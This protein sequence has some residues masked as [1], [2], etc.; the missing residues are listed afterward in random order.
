MKGMDYSLLKNGNPW[1][2]SDINKG[3]NQWKRQ[4]SFN[5]CKDNVVRKS[6]FG[7]HHKTKQNWFSIHPMD[8]KPTRWKFVRNKIFMSSWP[9]SLHYYCREK[10]GT[11]RWETWHLN[12]AI[13]TPHIMVQINIISFLIRRIEREVSFLWYACQKCKIWI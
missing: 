1:V 3:V 4:I 10:I 9:M 11:L 6:L 8:A 2:H 12:Q 7:N 13:Q 5:K